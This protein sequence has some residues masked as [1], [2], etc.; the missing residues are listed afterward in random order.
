MRPKVGIQEQI[1]QCLLLFP[2]GKDDPEY[3]D[4]FKDL[5]VEF[6]QQGLSVGAF[7]EDPNG[8]KPILAGC[9]VLGLTFEGEKIDYDS[10]KVILIG[11][12][13]FITLQRVYVGFELVIWRVA[14]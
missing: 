5:W 14:L 1:R 6:L 8:G 12:Q 11:I 10:L 2:D 13:I 4:T 3:V 9:N 7:V